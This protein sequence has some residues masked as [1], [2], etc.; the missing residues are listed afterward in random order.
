M[1]KFIRHFSQ[2]ATPLHA[3][4]WAN[5]KF[6]WTIKYTNTFKLLKWKISEAQ[7]LALLNLQRTFEVEADALNYALGAILLQNG[8]PS[9]L[10][11]YV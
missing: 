3:L 4:T 11:L 2:V 10:F 7:V 6:E 9:L 8:R 5:Q 1:R